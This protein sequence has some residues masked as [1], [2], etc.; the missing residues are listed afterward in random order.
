MKYFFLFAIV[1]FIT[2]CNKEN[3]TKL[4]TTIAEYQV[5][6]DTKSN[7]IYQRA[8]SEKKYWSK[9]LRP[10][11]SG[12]GELGPLANAYL[13]LYYATGDEK[14]LLHAE[15][16]LKKAIEI[17]AKNKD[18]YIRDLSGIYIKQEKIIEAKQLL[19]ES[20]K[21]KSNKRETQLLLFDVY[22]ESN[23]WNKADSILGIL[24]N[25]TDY[26]YLI[27]EAKWHIYKQN[28]KAA[29]RNY[30][31]ALSIA[32]S[33]NSKPL[34]LETN[35]YIATYY[36]EKEYYKE[37]YNYTLQALKTQPDAPKALQNLAYLLYIYF[38]DYKEA[39]RLIEHLQQTY[40]STE[41]S[42]L[43]KEVLKN[44]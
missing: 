35:L 1:L 18:R 32:E 22:F 9:R 42:E 21:T 20:Y 36:L 39:L 17:S 43:K 27:K 34:L 23:D 44:I 19:E 38:K 8:S 4:K 26:T 16:I 2:S 11:S 10:D 3:K 5:Y 31:K 41:L 37:S 12:I 15:K 7:T 13:Q 14:E 30:E 24:K 33:R 6:L 28:D 25:R 29:L 40:N